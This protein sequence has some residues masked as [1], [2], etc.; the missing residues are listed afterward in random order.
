MRMRRKEKKELKTKQ[1]INNF[2]IEIVSYGQQKYVLNDKNNNNKGN[3]NNKTKIE[4]L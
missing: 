1:A 4:F 2:R 3:N